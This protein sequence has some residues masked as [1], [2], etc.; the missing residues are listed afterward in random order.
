[1]KFGINTLL[2]TAGFDHSH[3]DLLPRFRELGFDAAEIARFEFGA[4]PAADVRRAVEAAGLEAV[5][6]SALTGDNSIVSD[7][8]ATRQRALRF[9]REGIETAAAIGAKVFVGPYCAPV[10]YLP[11][12][13]RTEDEW[14]RA[15]EGLQ[16]L[17]PVLDTYDVQ[18]AVEPLNRFETY[19]LNTI[20]DAVKLCDE[21]GHPRVGILYDT[22]HANIEEKSLPAALAAAVPH[23]KHVHTCENDRGIPGSGHVEWTETL[24]TLANSAYDAY[25]SIESFG[26]RIPEIAAAACIWRDLA[27]SSDA[28]AA[29]GLKFLK[30]HLAGHSGTEKISA[31]SM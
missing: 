19:F 30:K 26:A 27:P 31:T 16:S 29:E 18:L 17:G 21:V 15:V 9:V 20:A 8:A 13:R 10:G 25:V 22:F 28:I 5:F 23:L 14:K 3:L 24:S 2:W 7:D 12:R 1:M 6:C 4:F 11:G